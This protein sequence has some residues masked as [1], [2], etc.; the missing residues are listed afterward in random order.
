M[1]WEMTGALSLLLNELETFQTFVSGHFVHRLSFLS[2]NLFGFAC[3]LLRLSGSSGLRL[4]M[5]LLFRL[6]LGLGFCLLAALW[7]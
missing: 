2:N 3:V 5:L 1:S 4:I 6:G 7:L